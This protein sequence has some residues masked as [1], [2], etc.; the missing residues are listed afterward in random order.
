M[1]E[2]GHL[3]LHLFALQL[4]LQE[5][6]EARHRGGALGVLLVG[7][8]RKRTMKRRRRASQNQLT[9]YAFTEIA[10]RGGGG[11]LNV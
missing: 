7:L 4:L 9:T 2:L 1:D 3:L 11:G 5:D 8:R 6:L 10:F